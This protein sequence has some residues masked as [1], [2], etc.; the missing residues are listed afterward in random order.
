VKVCRDKGNPQGVGVTTGGD[1]ER[2]LPPVPPLDGFWPKFSSS[3][4]LIKSIRIFIVN[5]RLSKPYALNARVW[6]RADKD[7]VVFISACVLHRVPCVSV[8]VC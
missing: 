4:C 6:K 7:A 3:N 2:R 8:A 1:G 5:P